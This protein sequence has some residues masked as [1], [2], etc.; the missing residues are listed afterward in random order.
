MIGRR[1]ATMGDAELPGDYCLVTEGDWV[2]PNGE[3]RI[4]FRLPL[5]STDPRLDEPGGR[6]L[7]CVQEPPHTFRHCPDGSVEVRA[8]ILTHF[9]TG[10]AQSWHGFL[11]EGHQWAEV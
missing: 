11:S 3:P 8:S 1:V 4:Y 9:G 10:G 7:A 2:G 6:S 5:D